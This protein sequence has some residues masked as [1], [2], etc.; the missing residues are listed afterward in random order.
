MKSLVTGGAGFIGSNLVKYL[1]SKNHEVTVLDK[2]SKKKASNLKGLLNKIDYFN[3]DISKKKEL[4]KYFKNIDYVFHLAALTSTM[5]SFKKKKKY[6]DNNVKATKNIIKAL[7][8]KKIKK[9]IYTASAS[10]YGNQKKI[11]INIFARISPENPY[12][13][14][15]YE[16]ERLLLNFSKKSKLPVVSLRLFNVYGKQMNNKSIYKSVI[17]IFLSQKKKNIPLTIIG[18]G[19][20]TRDFIYISDVLSALLKAAKL[21]KYVKI[22][23]VASG[24]KTSIN[25]LANLISKKKKYYRKRKGEIYHSL[26]DI[27]VTKSK[28]NW[29]PK[30]SIKKGLNL[31][32]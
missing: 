26:A 24:K 17:N 7:K 27:S 25:Y 11:P 31:I 28:L 29:K 10:C 21:K 18:D 32:T 22:L 9:L 2:Q 19:N 8:R 13:K 6:F 3:I 30:V 14:T 23:N 4:D 12:A 15:K 1:V 16:S 5:E 20:Q